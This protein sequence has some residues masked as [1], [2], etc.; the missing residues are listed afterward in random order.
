[1]KICERQIFAGGY[2][3]ISQKSEDIRQSE[4]TAICKDEI[5]VREACVDIR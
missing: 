4:Q 5:V 3:L 1:M 2:L